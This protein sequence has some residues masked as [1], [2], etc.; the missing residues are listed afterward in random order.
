[1]KNSATRGASRSHSLS[2]PTRADGHA[3]QDQASRSGHAPASERQSRRN[4]L[5]LWLVLHAS[6]QDRVG[7][8]RFVAGIAGHVHV[9]MIPMDDRVHLSRLPDR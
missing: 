5:P 8:E 3:L 7:P 9:L 4:G 6:W 2:P 1:M